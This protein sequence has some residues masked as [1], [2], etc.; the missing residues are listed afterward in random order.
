MMDYSLPEGQLKQRLL[1]MSKT[2]R[3][4]FAAVTK[5]VI[6][7]EFLG[8]WKKADLISEVIVGLAGMEISTPQLRWEQTVGSTLSAALHANY[9]ISTDA[10]YAISTNKPNEGEM[11]QSR[12]EI[13][14]L[15]F[16]KLIDEMYAPIYLV[17]PLLAATQSPECEDVAK[18][19]LDRMDQRKLGMADRDTMKKIACVAM[20]SIAD[21]KNKDYAKR[22]LVKI[23]D[24]E[25]GNLIQLV[26]PLL[27]ATDSPKYGDIAR[28]LLDRMGGKRLGVAEGDTMKKIASAGTAAMADATCRDCAKRILGT[29]IADGQSNLIYLAGPLLAATRNPEQGQ[30]AMELLD[31]MDGKRLG[32]ADAETMK[33]IAS[34][35]TASIARD[36]QKDYAKRVLGRIIDEAPCNLIY[37]AGPLL[38]ATRNPE[39]GQIAMELL[40]AMDGKRLGSADAETMKK[41]ASIGSA[42]MADSRNREYA[43]KLLWKII[44]EG[45]CDLIYFVGPLVA[46]TQ[47]PEQSQIARGLL[48]AMTGK[49]LGK[50]DEST[51]ECITRVFRAARYSII[52]SQY[53]EEFTA[54]LKKEEGISLKLNT[55]YQA[56]QWR[57]GN[58]H[59]N[60]HANGNGHSNGHGQANNGNGHANNGQGH[61]STKRRF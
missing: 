40:D 11:R 53:V 4:S 49:K 57:P 17:V 26:G 43:G 30:I 48:D 3:A 32:A 19:L 29:V 41:I 60:G 33:K 50:G 35:G 38:A 44:C 1:R 54:K 42:A 2:S 61:P 16:H 14:Q 10:P 23:I 9:S 25:R 39:Q 47:D 5:G 24:E 55:A 37:L 36:K 18:E 8:D 52:Q 7:W 56:P 58:G 34:I 20:A 6:H 22:L 31:A 46:A 21:G 12:A 45:K 15:I 51:I 13:A 28:E 27:A 59:T